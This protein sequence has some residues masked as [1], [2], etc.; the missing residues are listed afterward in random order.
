MS[1]QD[2]IK[3]GLLGMIE[4]GT[5]F[6]NAL[7]GIVKHAYEVG[8][9]GLLSVGLC[10]YT[11]M[12]VQRFC[13]ADA[14]VRYEVCKDRAETV[15]LL[16]QYGSETYAEIDRIGR[17]HAANCLANPNEPF[18]EP[19]LDG[20]DSATLEKIGEHLK[21]A[22]NYGHRYAYSLLEAQEAAAELGDMEVIM[23]TLNVAHVMEQYVETFRNSLPRYALDLSSEE[24]ELM[25]PA[26][27]NQ[28]AE[29]K[30]DAK[31]KLAEYIDMY[32]R[33]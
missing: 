18:A 25:F 17:E 15:K 28:D 29:K 24:I 1:N 27:S 14:L 2:N 4:H 12:R 10:V 19:D 20:A 22:L 31:S 13:L 11:A 32:A 8:D 7:F 23:M 6:R 26:L 9:K 21:D 16:K 3:K 33:S 5:G 30:Q